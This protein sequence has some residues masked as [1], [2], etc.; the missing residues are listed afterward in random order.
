M[1]AGR[2]GS[3]VQGQGVRKKVNKGIAPREI[4]LAAVE[5]KPALAATLKALDSVNGL[6]HHFLLPRRGYAGLRA[7]PPRPPAGHGL[8]GFFLPITSDQLIP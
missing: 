2:D 4:S 6:A 8:R 3:G 5:G 1:L 7:A